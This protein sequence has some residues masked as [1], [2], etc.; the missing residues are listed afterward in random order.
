MVKNVILDPLSCGNS[1]TSS[2]ILPNKSNKNLK[3]FNHGDEN[4]LKFG[5]TI[6]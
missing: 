3:D 5:Q 6:V 1:V 4:V 2:K